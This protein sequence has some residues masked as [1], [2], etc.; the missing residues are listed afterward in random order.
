MVVDV[1]KGSDY[2]TIAEATAAGHRVVFSGCYYLDHLVR[3][4]GLCDVQTLMVHTAQHTT[5]GSFDAWEFYKCDPWAFNGTNEQK[6]VTR[7]ASF[8]WA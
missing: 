3:G 8:V 4:T 2:T 1:W 5:P 7:V 6:V